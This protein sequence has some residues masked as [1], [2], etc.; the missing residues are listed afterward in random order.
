MKKYLLKCS[1]ERQL[2]LRS[3]MSWDEM[4]KNILSQSQ[5]DNKSLKTVFKTFGKWIPFCSGIS[6]PIIYLSLLLLILP[7]S[8][9]ARENIKGIKLIELSHEELLNFNI[10]I[11]DDRLIYQEFNIQGFNQTGRADVGNGLEMSFDEVVIRQ[12][13]IG[14]MNINIKNDDEAEPDEIF[15]TARFA[16]NNFKSGSTAYFARR[17]DVNDVVF[18]DKNYPGQSIYAYA[19]ANS[20]VGIHVKLESPDPNVVYNDIYLWYEP[21]ALFLERLPERFI[22]ELKKELEPGDEPLPEDSYTDINRDNAEFLKYLTLYPNP[23]NS[24]FANLK[25]R[26]SEQ[27]NISITIHDISG[28][29]IK[30]ISNNENIGAGEHNIKMELNDIAAGMYLISIVCE[31]G[32]QIVKRLIVTN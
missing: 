18:D 32:E 8:L 16:V 7:L 11:E 2:L 21:T 22:S 17:S 9:I 29:L 5:S 27:R 19:D 15:P 28:R 13:E 4:D 20:L 30:S 12:V 1:W 6:K 10:T 25:F 31:S 24:G 3:Q 23:A 26:L 14:G